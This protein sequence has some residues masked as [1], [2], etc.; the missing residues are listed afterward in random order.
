MAGWEIPRKWRVYESNGKVIK[1]MKDFRS[2]LLK[3]P[4]PLRNPPPVGHHGHPIP[5]IGFISQKPWR[6]PEEKGRA[7]SAAEAP[8]MWWKDVMLGPWNGV[9][10]G[11]YQ[12]RMLCE[13]TILGHRLKCNRHVQL[14]SSNVF[15]SVQYILDVFHVDCIGVIT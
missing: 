6:R 12:K 4:R 15:Q 10:L 2:N 3:S 5:S 14:T 13:S 8:G 7:D 9:V 11:Y 1:I